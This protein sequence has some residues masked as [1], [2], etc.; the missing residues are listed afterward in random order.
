M[1]LES[2]WIR[3]GAVSLLALLASCDGQSANVSAVQQPVIPTS[4]SQS[5]APLDQYGNAHRADEVRCASNLSIERPQVLALLYLSK[6]LIGE[7]QFGKNGEFAV[8]GAENI[9]IE[10]IDSSL[11]R[12]A[13]KATG[14][15]V[16]NPGVVL[17]MDVD[18]DGVA[19]PYGCTPAKS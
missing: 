1:S 14:P 11:R 4:I 19:G 7:V 8:S 13:V 2:K 12:M 10:P 17:D 5:R 16:E 15:Y 18:K 3:R 6:Q 9:S